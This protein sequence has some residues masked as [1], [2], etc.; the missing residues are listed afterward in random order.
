MV[1]ASTLHRQ[2]MFVGDK[3]LELLQN[4][5]FAL[6]EK[7]N[8][9]LQ[10]WAVFPNHYHFIAEAPANA[11]TL[12]ALIRQLHSLTARELNKKD[13]VVGRRVWFQYWDTCLTYEKSYYARL[14]YVINNPVHHKIVPVA[15]N[16]PFCSARW[17]D[18]HGDSNFVHKVRSFKY[19]QVNVYDEF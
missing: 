19:D 6:C 3:R 4:S 16:Y 10:A 14:N 2:K 5:L 11:E 15:S 9:Q 7:F 8:W 13:G 18:S 17:F 12:K 1:T